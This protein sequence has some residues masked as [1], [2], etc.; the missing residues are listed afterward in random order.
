MFWAK[1][2]KKGRDERER[3][4]ETWARDAGIGQLGVER[5]E[6]AVAEETEKQPLVFELVVKGHVVDEVFGLKLQSLF[7][8]LL[9]GWREEELD[10][11][12]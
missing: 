9:A 7:Y 8:C 6:V 10:V 5:L 12:L 1:K 3:W 2:S 11:S 4:N